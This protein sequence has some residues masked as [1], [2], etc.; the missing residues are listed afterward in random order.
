M[1]HLFEIGNW[2]LEVMRVYNRG[3]DNLKPS[4]QMLHSF[5]IK[6]AY[7]FETQAPNEDVVLVLRAHPI[8]Q[9][10]WVINSFILLVALVFLN[11]FFPNFLTFSQIVFANFFAAAFIF[12]YVWFNFLSWYFNVGVVTNKRIVDIDFHAVIYKEISEALLSKVED[13]TDKSAGFFASVFNYGTVYV[14]TAGSEVNIEFENVPKPADVV[15]IIN[16][17]V[18]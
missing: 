17:L 1:N 15:K 4:N 12:A 16:Q 18:T 9:V 6:P 3:M 2:E 11:F 5:N 7:R 10:P 8:T 13:V 14:Q